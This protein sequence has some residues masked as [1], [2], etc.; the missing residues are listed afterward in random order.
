MTIWTDGRAPPST[1]ALHTYS[2]FTTG[3]WEGDT[4]ITLTTHLK[5]NFLERNGTPSSN[6]ETYEM[7]MARHGDQMAITGVIRDPVYLSAP[8][9][10]AA[11]LALRVDT[12]A[13]INNSVLY[14]MPAEL[15]AVS[16]GFHSATELPNAIQSLKM[17]QTEH[18]NIPLDAAMGG[19]QTQY[20][21]FRKR[22][23]SEGYKPPSAYCKI[24]CC[25][26]GSRVCRNSN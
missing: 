7:F 9:V 22:I 21:E 2:G 1:E 25:D 23:L 15:E 16:D 11:T 19:P 24:V 17:Y 13:T 14:C 6:Q 5:D 26:L 10:I 3:K 18:Y 20:P 8:W 4:L 12:G